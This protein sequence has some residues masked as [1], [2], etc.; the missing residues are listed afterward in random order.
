MTQQLLE[1]RSSYIRVPIALLV[2]AALVN[3]AIAC[4][5]K[6]GYQ[7]LDWLRTITHAL[8]RPFGSSA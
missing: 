2:L 7:I 8:R 5:Y 4:F 1:T 3:G 6:F